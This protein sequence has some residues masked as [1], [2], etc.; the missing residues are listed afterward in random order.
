[1]NLPVTRLPL[2]VVVVGLVAAGAGHAGRPKVGPPPPKLY[3]AVGHTKTVTLKDAHGKLVVSLKPGWYT[4]TISDA[5]SDQRFRLTGP[6]INRS[7]GS[8]FVGAQIW[9]VNLRQGTYRYQTV[10]QKLASRSFKVG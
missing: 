9:G 10:G 4:L 7:T 5:S 3:G 8:A 1:M 2:A 6:G